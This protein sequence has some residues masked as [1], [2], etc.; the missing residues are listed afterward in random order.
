MRKLAPV[1]VGLG[2]FLL[3]AGLIALLWAPGVVKKTPLDVD[4]TTRL[5]GEAARVDTATGELGEALPVKAVSISQ[6]DSEVSTDSTVV[7]TNKQCLTLD[8]GDAPDC[9]D[10]RTDERAVNVS[11][12]VFATDRVTALAV[13][14]DALPADAVP[15]EGVV[16]KWPFDAEQKTYPYWDGLVGE[17]VDADFDRTETVD[18]LE[19]N[20]YV[21]EI[22]DAPIE[23]AEGVEGTYD[24]SKEIWV[25]PVAGSIVNQIDDQQRYLA[26]GTQALDL[27]LAFTEEQ[28][29]TNVEEAKSNGTSV[30]LVTF[31]IPVVGIVGGLLA[32]VGGLVLMV[33]GRRHDG[34]APTSHTRVEQP[35]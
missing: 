9:P 12:D 17:A 22:S 16:N 2:A 15:H 8:E 1:L 14:S 35:V 3:V 25:D 31:W 13:D 34:P 20:V 24:D 27:Q 10:P 33:R 19:L 4:T 26:D 18:G 30:R 7:F 29:A 32:L 21:V 6:A 28:V 11:T 23:V 5:S